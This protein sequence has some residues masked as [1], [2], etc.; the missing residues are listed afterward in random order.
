[1]WP[2]PPSCSGHLW[3]FSR[4]SIVYIPWEVN[5]QQNIQGWNSC[6]TGMWVP[7]F[8]ETWWTKYSLSDQSL[9]LGAIS[10]SNSYW[11][12]WSQ[13]RD[14]FTATCILNSLL[15]CNPAEPVQ[16]NLSVYWKRRITSKRLMSHQK[17]AVNKVTG[18]PISPS[19]SSF[20]YTSHQGH[21]CPFYP[22]PCKEG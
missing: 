1:M 22:A 11:C 7:E 8:P 20:L 4:T 18:Q 13:G 19:P 9:G 6:P 14:W 21:I 16:H 12:T 17:A 3:H 2:P 5:F 10:C 15:Y